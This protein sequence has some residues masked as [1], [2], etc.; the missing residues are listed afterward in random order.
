MGRDFCV[1]CVSG[2]ENSR[3]LE[4]FARCR[5]VGVN[6][7]T[8]GFCVFFVGKLGDREFCEIGIAEEFG[9]VEEGAAEGFSGEMDGFG[10]AAAG[11]RE[12]VTFQNIQRFNQHCAAR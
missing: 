3:T 5:V 8:P 2:A 10:G 7:G 9:A 11:F 12:V 6:C 1:C 4:I